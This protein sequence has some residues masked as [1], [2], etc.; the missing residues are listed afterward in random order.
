MR[1]YLLT[2]NGQV[3]HTTYETYRLCFVVVICLLHTLAGS[4]SASLLMFWSSGIAA[5]ASRC[6]ALAGLDTCL[7]IMQVIYEGT[8]DSKYR[9]C[10]L[11]R[12]YVDAGKLLPCLL[13][14]SVLCIHQLCLRLNSG[15]CN[16]ITAM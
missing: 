8:G 2:T 16:A 9:P 12:Q 7:A 3:R 10:P 14:L 1:G 5:C 15:A 6:A 4:G 11:L 13:L